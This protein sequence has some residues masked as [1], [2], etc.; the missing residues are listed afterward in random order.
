MSCK[1]RIVRQKVT[2]F[3]PSWK[4]ASIMTSPSISF[5]FVK[6]RKNT[7][8]KGMKC[9]ISNCHLKIAIFVLYK[10]FNNNIKGVEII[11]QSNF[12]SDCD[13]QII[14][15]IRRYDKIRILN[16]RIRLSSDEPKIHHSPWWQQYGHLICH[17]G[18]L[19]KL[20][21]VIMEGKIH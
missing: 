10:L 11:S 18:H 5:I 14:H 3:N 7:I 4:Q 20:Q 6:L 12:R 17:S 13:N 8:R 21:S 9:Q 19:N 2:I 15:S 16:R 1:I